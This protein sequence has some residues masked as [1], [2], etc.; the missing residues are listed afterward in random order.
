M[1]H[2]EQPRPS[3]YSANCHQCELSIETTGQKGATVSKTR[4]IIETAL[5]AL[6]LPLPV[7]T[8]LSPSWIET[9]FGMSPDAGDGR[10]EWL[11][12]VGLLAMSLIT[13]SLAWRGH[14]RFRATRA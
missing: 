8:V 12:A 2:C 5:A 9:V 10:A 4:L 6:S 1:R 7:L 14:S 11:I 13:S 3:P